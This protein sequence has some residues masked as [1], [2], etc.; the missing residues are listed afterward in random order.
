MWQAR[1]GEDR[2]R[3]MRI[4]LIVPA[5]TP[6]T[7]GDRRSPAGVGRLWRDAVL[8]QPTP[9]FGVGVLRKPGTILILSWSP[10]ITI[11]RQ[12][13]IPCFAGSVYRNHGSKAKIRRP[14][15]TGVI[16]GIY[17]GFYTFPL[18]TPFFDSAEGQFD[19]K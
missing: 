5:Y 14:V 2:L 1:A 11:L 12:I 10:G 13:A 16:P 17:G 9:A 4:T 6:R 3:W 7:G 15:R 19:C 18:F 8:G